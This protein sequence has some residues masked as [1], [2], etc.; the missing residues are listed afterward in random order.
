[1]GNFMRNKNLS[2]VE[3]FLF[4]LF[5]VTDNTNLLSESAFLTTGEARKLAFLS[6]LY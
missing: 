3:I 4:F 5:R 2:L 6:S 1:M